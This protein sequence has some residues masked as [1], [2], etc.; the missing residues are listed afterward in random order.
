[1][2]ITDSQISSNEA[3]SSLSADGAGLA[4]GSGTATISGSTIEDNHAGNPPDPQ[5]GQ[6][7][8]IYF[9]GT[10]ASD[11]LT[12]EDSAI[13]Q[14]TTRSSG[15]GLTV[16]GSDVSVD[17][18]DTTVIGNQARSGAGLNAIN[19]SSLGLLRTRVVGNQ[20]SSDFDTPGGGILVGDIG[21]GASLD[22]VDSVVSANSV[23]G[24]SGGVKAYGGGIDVTQSSEMRIVGTEIAGNTATGD[25][26]YGG[27]IAQAGSS[28]GVV[29]NSTVNGN[30]AGG[31]RFHGR[32]RHGVLQRGHA[33]PDQRQRR[34]QLRRVGNGLGRLSTGTLNLT[35]S[36]LDQP[37]A[38]AA[39]AGS[40][41][42]AATS[43]ARRAIPACSARR[44]ISRRPT[45]VSGPSAPTVD[46]RR[47]R[48]VRSRTCARSRSL[49]RAR[50][51]TTW[52]SPIASTSSRL[53]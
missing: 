48:A 46:R 1:M 18:V 50:R 36:A 35:N 41:P 2:T 39:P 51:M 15:G 14:N 28:T 52:R 4:L 3:A 10:S 30:G 45:P 6:G 32:G 17:L 5:G 44:A 42:G 53:R 26:G 12:I 49:P 22:V 19:G 40:R 31:T 9:T 7:G 37:T 11:Q 24:T 34:R 13:S 16:S 23:E 20:A 21:T 47:E 27:G 33:R 29:L 8:G 43:A 25:P 38:P